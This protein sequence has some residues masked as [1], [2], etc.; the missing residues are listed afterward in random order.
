M[1][2]RHLLAALTASAPV[3]LAG[4]G[5]VAALMLATDQEYVLGTSVVGL[6]AL[7]TS[8][9]AIQKGTSPFVRQF[10]AFEANEQTGLSQALLTLGAPPPPG[11]PA[12]RAAMLAR[13]Q[14]M[15]RGP[16]FDRMYVQGQIM[17]HQEL[18]AI[19]VAH[20]QRGGSRETLALAR[21]ALP[22]I[23]Q[24]L[25]QLQGLRRV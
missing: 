8:R 17:G 16:A 13:L 24:H 6:L 5:P 19:Q 20:L 25:S 22:T 18:R 23:D 15:P 14:A 3:A 1:N 10:A 2:R 12:D 7:E 9:I 11:L 4:T 21:A